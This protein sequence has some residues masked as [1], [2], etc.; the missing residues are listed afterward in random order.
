MSHPAKNSFQIP[1]FSYSKTIL[2]TNSYLLLFYTEFPYSQEDIKIFVILYPI[3][4][5]T[6]VGV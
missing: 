6:H 2:R 5:H 1:T 4:I 3:F